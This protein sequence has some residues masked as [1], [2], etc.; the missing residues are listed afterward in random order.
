MTTF[1]GT[2]IVAGRGAGEALVTRTPI[3]FTAAFTK[4]HNL[5]PW[6]RGEIRDRHHDRFRSNV[7]G[8]VL[9]F[10]ACVG[11]TFTGMVLMQ[12]VSEEKGPAAIVVQNAD[13][14]LVSGA[15][16]AQVWFSKGVPVVE[17]QPEDLFEKIR[18]GDNVA[19]DGDTG[20]ISV[21]T[22]LGEC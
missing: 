14:L 6:R 15:V 22:E 12:L 18:P 10:P 7:A 9:V 4:P 3:N 2:A 13:S 20:E 21:G 8:K 16:L 17:Y 19:V 1:K 5:L 11:S